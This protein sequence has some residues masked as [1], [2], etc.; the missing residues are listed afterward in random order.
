LDT[1][2]R[3][4]RSDNL[5]PKSTAATFAMEP[6]NLPTALRSAAVMTTSFMYASGD[7]P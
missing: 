6:L 7:L 1:G 2:T 3:Q 5:A 4:Q